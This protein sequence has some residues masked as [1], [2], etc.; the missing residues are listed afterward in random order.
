MKLAPR[1]WTLVDMFFPLSFRNMFILHKKT[2]KSNWKASYRPSIISKTLDLWCSKTF[3]VTGELLSLL[4]WGQTLALLF[5]VTARSSL[6]LTP[7]FLLLIVTSSNNLLSSWE[8]WV[9]NDLLILSKVI[10]C[11]IFAWNSR[12]LGEFVVDIGLMGLL[13]L[14]LTKVTK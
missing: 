2:S 12:R 6:L 7:G 5:L 13:C 14:Y 4:L 8:S 11:N 1:N 9:P 10:N 3:V